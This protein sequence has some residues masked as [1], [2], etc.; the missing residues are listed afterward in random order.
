M[1]VFKAEPSSLC[2][3]ETKI[4][5]TSKAMLITILYLQCESFVASFNIEWGRISTQEVAGGFSQM[6]PAFKTAWVEKE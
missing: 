3:N 1:L 5:W 4:A 6:H 2:L